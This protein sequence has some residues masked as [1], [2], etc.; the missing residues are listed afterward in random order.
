MQCERSREYIEKKLLIDAEAQIVRSGIDA[1]TEREYPLFKERVELLGLEKEELKKKLETERKALD[2][3]LEYRNHLIKEEE[4]RERMNGEICSLKD[5]IVGKEKVVSDLQNKLHISE[6]EYKS[7]T[8]RMLTLIEDLSNKSCE[9]EKK[10]S[11]LSELEEV[12]VEVDGVSQPSWQVIEEEQRRDFARS[13]SQQDYI[14]E[15][16]V[17]VEQIFN[18][19]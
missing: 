7:T 15:I 8:T 11:S 14:K 2:V 6:Q 17:N 16:K 13:L 1:I 18:F 4:Q 19:G 12:L 3:L 10:S 9:L 5:S